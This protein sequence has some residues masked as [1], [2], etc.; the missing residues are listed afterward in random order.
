MQL[1]VIRYI[2]VIR[3]MQQV[4]MKLGN[5]TSKKSIITYLPLA[6][7]LFSVKLHCGKS[8]VYCFRIHDSCIVHIF[9]GRGFRVERV[10]VENRLFNPFIDHVSRLICLDDSLDPTRTM[11]DSPRKPMTMKHFAGPAPRRLMHHSELCEGKF[12]SSLHCHPTFP[13]KTKF[14]YKISSL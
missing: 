11:S 2:I 14:L 1:S 10:L 4:N 5:L 3:G 7:K 13:G 9:W 12:V 8:Y 6:F